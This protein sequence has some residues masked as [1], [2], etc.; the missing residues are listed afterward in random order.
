MYRGVLIAVVAAIVVGAATLAF[1]NLKAPPNDFVHIGVNDKNKVEIAKKV[2]IKRRAGQKTTSVVSLEAKD[3]GPIRKGQRVRGIGEVE[4]SVTCTEPMPQCVGSIYKYSPH[5]KAQLVIAKSPRSTKGEKLGK[6]VKK[7]CSQS[8]PNRNHHCVLLLDRTK[9]AKRSCSHCSLNIVLTAWHKKAR[10]KD[11]L[12]IGADSDHGIDQ[13]KASISAAVFQRDPKPTTRTYR[14]KK[15]LTKKVPVVDSSS[16]TED[17]VLASVRL[18]GLKKGDALLVSARAKV[19][20]GGLGY[21]VLTQ[22]E[23]IVSQKG[24]KSTS[25]K[26]LPVA[27]VSDNGRIA[28]QTGYNCTQGSSDYRDPCPID[29]AGAAYMEYSAIQKPF[30]DKGASKPLWINLVS[31]FGAQYGKPYH[32]GDKVKVKQ[33]VIRVVRIG[34][35]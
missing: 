14:S 31:A 5:V 29:K 35:G 1:A 34:A 23:V 9:R 7:T 25:N 2:P 8:Y 15:V 30:T 16:D 11:T 6:A 13:G 26:G 4:V 12:V 19:G 24:P 28:T 21:N 33:A 22:S 20:I 10:G 17:A 32:H 3:L 18:D 27:V